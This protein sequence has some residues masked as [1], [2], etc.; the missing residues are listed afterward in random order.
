MLRV[1]TCGRLVEQQYRRAMHDRLSKER[2]P[3]KASG[4]V[5]E[6]LARAIDELHCRQGCLHCCGATAD[7]HTLQPGGVGKRLSNGEVARK[8]SLLRQEPKV[9]AGFPTTRSV[10]EITAEK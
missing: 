4:Q 2:P 1:D 7:R 3:P 5:P 9:T 10:G 8:V 6:M